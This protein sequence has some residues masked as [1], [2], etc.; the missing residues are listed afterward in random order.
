MPLL[1]IIPMNI[2]SVFREFFFVN[3]LIVLLN[4]YFHL[5]MLI[6]PFSQADRKVME[7]ALS[8][9]FQTAYHS[10]VLAVVYAQQSVAILRVRK[11]SS[12]FSTLDI[13]ILDAPPFCIFVYSH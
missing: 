11:L 1:N 12:I 9:S 6:F 10:G 5:F 13:Y 2:V 3:E 4:Y 7:R 8:Q